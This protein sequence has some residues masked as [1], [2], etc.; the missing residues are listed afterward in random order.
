MHV[1]CSSGE[2]AI[3]TKKLREQTGSSRDSTHAGEQDAEKEE[4]HC[5][6]QLF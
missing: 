3:S 2:I 1:T 5:D 6:E 4:L